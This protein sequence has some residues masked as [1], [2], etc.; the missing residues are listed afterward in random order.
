M[1]EVILLCGAAS[2]FMLCGLILNKI[3]FT[4]QD[5]DQRLSI[6]S[7]YSSVSLAFEHIEEVDSLSSILEIFSQECPSCQINLFYGSA[8]D[9]RQQLNTGKLDLGFIRTVPDSQMDSSFD[10]YCF[11]LDEHVI[12]CQTA[13]LPIIPLNRQKHTEAAVWKKGNC[14]P[15]TILL[16]SLLKKDMLKKEVA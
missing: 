9:I 13:E 4:N 3:L 15:E 2:I 1:K 7:N 14:T 5:K 8:E 11:L 12:A 16:I 6:E 10:F